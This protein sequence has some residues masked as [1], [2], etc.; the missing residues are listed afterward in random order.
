MDSRLGCW[1]SGAGC[2]RRLM[3]RG[4]K[5]S[6]PRMRSTTRLRLIEAHGLRQR[7][8]E[9]ID[10]QSCVR[11]YCLVPPVLR[12]MGLSAANADRA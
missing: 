3:W 1:L 10:N 8:S 11:R 7:L 4:R 5:R 12:S 9:R 6:R 2:L